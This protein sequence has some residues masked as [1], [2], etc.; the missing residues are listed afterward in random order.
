MTL[1]TV[2][3]IPEHTITRHTELTTPATVRMVRRRLRVRP[4]NVIRQRVGIRRSGGSSRSATL[5]PP[6]ALGGENSHRFGWADPRCSARRGPRR[7]CGCRRA[8]DGSDDQTGGMHRRHPQRQSQRADVLGGEPAAENMAADQAPRCFPQQRPRH[9]K[10][11]SGY[12]SFD[13]TIRWLTAFRSP[14]VGRSRAATTA[15]RSRPPLL[16]GTPTAAAWRTCVPIRRFCATHCRTAAR[17]A[18]R[19]LVHA[20]VPIPL[21]R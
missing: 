8:G 13:R 17:H 9:R 7:Q 3:R 2:S 14:L 19:P 12:E 20:S 4:R 11:D 16:P 15:H 6:R 21:R 10:S 5:T 18:T 1:L